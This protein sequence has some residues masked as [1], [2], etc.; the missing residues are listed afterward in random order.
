MR[1]VHFQRLETIGHFSLDDEASEMRMVYVH[2]LDP[3]P[4]L[5]LLL[6]YYSVQMKLESDNQSLEQNAHPADLGK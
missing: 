6:A 5:P 1:R 4:S 2:Y 3:D